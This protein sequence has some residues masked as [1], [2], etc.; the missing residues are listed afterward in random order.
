MRLSGIIYRSAALALLI[1]AGCS[2]DTPAGPGPIEPGEG[3]LTGTITADRTLYADTVYTLSGFVK[4]ANGATLTIQPGTRIEGD[5]NVVGSS[6]FILRGARIVAAGTAQK[7]I[8]FTSSRPEGQRRPGDWGGIVI[9]G[10]G[11]INRTG[12]TVIEGT[13]TDATL[14]PTQDYSGGTNNADNSGVLRYARIEFAG[15]PTAPNQELN[16][17]TLAAVGSGTT[18]EYVQVLLGLDDSFEWFGG[19]VD[20]RYLVSYEAGDDHF[21]MSEGYVG[22]VQFA[23]AF[24]SFQPE[25]RPGLSGGVASDPQGIENDGCAATNCIGG[26]NNRNAEPY[27]VPVI[28]NFTLVGAPQGAWE[29]TGGNRG[30]MIRRGSG[31]LYL[32]GVVARYSVAGISIVGDATM[33]RAD[34]GLLAIR[35][36]HVS[37][38]ASNNT[39]QPASGSG[40]SGVYTLPLAANQITTDAGLPGNLFVSLPNA[41][42]GTGPGDFDWRPAPGSQIASGGLTNLS[43]LPATLRTRAQ[44]FIVPTAYRGAADPNGPKWWEAWTSYARD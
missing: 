18:I 12:E 33:A 15:F 5:Y 19:A 6:L 4:V 20:A 3:T 28:A 29:T 26:P 14:N 34:A 38:I 16:A 31:G 43:E 2:D 32:N 21:D 10:N 13:G 30:M 44:G 23:I 1:T 7:P 17:L 35:N 9:V 8:V 24:Q 22:R 40:D 42:S 41:G 39:F 27:T 25:P 37:G 11:I 36:L